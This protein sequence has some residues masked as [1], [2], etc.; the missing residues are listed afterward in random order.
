M[1]LEAI[2]SLIFFA[3]ERFLKWSYAIHS[4]NAISS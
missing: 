3:L 1:S 4:I 2:T